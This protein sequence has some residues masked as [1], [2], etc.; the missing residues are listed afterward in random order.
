MNRK[1][2]QQR[3]GK[4]TDRHEKTHSPRILS[5]KWGKMEVED[6]GR[7][8]DFKL[9]PGGGKGWNWQ[10]HGTSHSPGI[11]VGDCEELVRN[12]CRVVVL[13]RGMLKRLKVTQEAL[14]YLQNND[15]EIVSEGTKKA[16][17]SYNRLARQ[18]R[19]VGGLFHSTC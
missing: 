3:E 6:I 7:G 17:A 5:L 10:E 18:G 1:A 2:N 13:S 4:M 14:D 12:G 11:Q 16:V 9:W 15:V 8:K 19:K